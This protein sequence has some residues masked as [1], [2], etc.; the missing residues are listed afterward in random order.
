MDAFLA[1]E[2]LQTLSSL[3]LLPFPKNSFGLLFGHKRGRRYIVEK[4]L[5]APEKFEPT[6]ENLEE[7]DRLFRGK[8][9]GLFGLELDPKKKTILL[10]PL[11]GG[12]LYLDVRRRKQGGLCL[13][14]FLVDYDGRFSFIPIGLVREKGART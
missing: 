1:I 9:V 4:A 6:A 3:R 14:P 12:R 2:A 13:K 7:L 5:P 8:L 11:A 10:Q